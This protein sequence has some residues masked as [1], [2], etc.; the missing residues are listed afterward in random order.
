MRSIQDDFHTKEW[1]TTAVA[2]LLGADLGLEG[3][4]E[5]FVDVQG[6]AVEVVEPLAATGP[7]RQERRHE[8]ARSKV[9]LHVVEQRRSRSG[10]D[11]ETRV[12]PGKIRVQTQENPVKL[13]KTRSNPVQARFN[14]IKLSETQYNP[15]KP[16]Q[17][18]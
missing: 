2:W 10:S 7:V 13:G 15:V 12:K 14:T 9:Q 1:W 5:H 16:S 6:G 18:R 4:L 3:L 8:H 17:I 11:P